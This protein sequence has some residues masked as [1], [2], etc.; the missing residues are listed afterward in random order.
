[1]TIRKLCTFFWLGLCITSANAQNP[2][3][4]TLQ[5]NTYFRSVVGNPTWLLIVRDMDTGIVLPYM[6]D[7]RNND[8]FWIA[9]TYGHSYRITASTLKWGPFAKIHNFCRLED[10]ILSR[11]SM[12]IS[13]S[14]NLT[15]YRYSS[16]CKVI[17]YKSI[18]FPV[19]TQ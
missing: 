10:G 13:L 4:Q 19:A 16:Y 11:Q 8:N 14:G 9:F 12:I 3:G 18:E 6:F 17:K 5:I 15:P 1:M 7:I 2:F